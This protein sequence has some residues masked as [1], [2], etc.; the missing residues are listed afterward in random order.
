MSDWQQVTDRLDVTEVC[1]RLHWLVD[2]RRWDRLDEVLDDQVSMP[3]I[4]EQSSEPEFD[5]TKYVRSLD[6][7]K[8]M[9]PRLL[10]GLTTQH[11]IAGHQ[12]TLDGDRAVCLAHSINVHVSDG[13]SEVGGQEVVTHGNEYRFELVR[14]DRG[15]RICGRQ[16]WITWSA[17]DKEI[18]DV[19]RKQSEWVGALH[20][21]RA[22]SPGSPE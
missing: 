13:G 14:T 6:E 19:R 9:Y 8:E 12:V 17:G 20:A 4:E 1:T 7:I 3:T 16:T 18:H 5:P 2:H 21:N 10:D 22:G 15:W 11:L